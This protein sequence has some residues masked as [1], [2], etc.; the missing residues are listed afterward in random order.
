MMELNPTC[1]TGNSTVS[2]TCATPLSALRSRYISL[3]TLLAK[4]P[5]I[6]LLDKGKKVGNI[7]AYVV[8]LVRPI[9]CADS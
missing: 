5:K 7:T 6:E 8:K 2:M 3:D 4:S 9:M 1:V